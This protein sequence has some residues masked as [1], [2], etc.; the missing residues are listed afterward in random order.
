M[1]LDWLQLQQVL[2]CVCEGGCV[3][4]VACRHHSRLLS[5]ACSEHKVHRP[6]LRHAVRA[7]GCAVLVATAAVGVC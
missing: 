1:V 7:G 3:R 6:L 2:L 4:S 5:V